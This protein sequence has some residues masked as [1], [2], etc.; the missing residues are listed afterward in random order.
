[1]QQELNSKKGLNSL[2]MSSERI[3]KLEMQIG[4]LQEGRDPAELKPH[5]L[6]IDEIMISEGSGGKCF[7]LED[8]AGS[9]FAD[10]RAQIYRQSF[11]WILEI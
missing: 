6:P 1:M 4:A 3:N 9:T 7:S 10:A 8:K 11:A 2:C 5:K